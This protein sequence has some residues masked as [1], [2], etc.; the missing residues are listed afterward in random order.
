MVK[1]SRGTWH[2][3]TTFEDE[4][5]L[6]IDFCNNPDL[7]FFA[8]SKHVSEANGPHWHFLFLFFHPKTLFEIAVSSDVAI[9][10]P[11]LSEASFEDYLRFLQQNGT[12]VTNY[13]KH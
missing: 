1:V 7:K 2:F 10:N 6:L 13:N 12:V 4:A 8:Y 5:E 11:A 3:V 9:F